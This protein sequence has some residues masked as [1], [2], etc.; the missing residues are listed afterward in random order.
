MDVTQ[1]ENPETES[2]ATEFIQTESPA[3]GFTIPVSQRTTAASLLA[4]AVVKADK[5]IHRYSWRGLGS[6]MHGRHI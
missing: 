3:S 1:E 4:M 6:K 5:D 2:F